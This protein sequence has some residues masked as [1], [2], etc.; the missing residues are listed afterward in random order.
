MTNVDHK[1][2][3]GFYVRACFF[4]LQYE[5]SLFVMGKCVPRTSYINVTLKEAKRKGKGKGGEGEIGIPVVKKYAIFGL[6]YG[7]SLL[8]KIVFP[9]EENLVTSRGSKIFVVLQLLMEL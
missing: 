9:R 7:R 6:V 3:L 8:M 2:S 1:L 5:F 4:K